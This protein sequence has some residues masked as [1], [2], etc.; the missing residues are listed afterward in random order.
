MKNLKRSASAL[1]SQQGS[2]PA[3]AGISTP[4][5][6]F[7]G[8]GFDLVIG[9]GAWSA[10]LLLLAGYCSSNYPQAVSI[11]F[12][13]LALI[14]N[15]PHYMA[16]VY[17]AYRTR[18]DFVKYKIFTLHLTLLIGL[19]LILTH[20]SSQLLAFVFTLYLTWSPF[21]YTGQNFGIALLFARRNG[22]KTTRGSR[23]AFHTAFLASYVM[24]FL[25]V[26]SFHSTDQF[27]VT[28][29]IPL[30][31]AR[32]LW[33]A[34][35][36]TFI[37]SSIYSLSAFVKQTGW[38]AMTAP[39][40]LLSTQVAW[41]V[42]PTALTLFSDI[43]FLQARS[44]TAILAV[45]HSA[46]Y[47][48]IT[49]YYARRESQADQ[50]SAQGNGWRFYAYF[51]VLI[52][53]G[54][55]LFVP[56]PWLASRVLHIDFM[57]SF[58]A[59]TALVNIHHFLLDGAIWKLRDGRI[60]SLLLNTHRVE[61]GTRAGSSFNQFTGWLAG[62][63]RS[64]RLFRVTA[65]LSLLFVAG[66]DQLKF[67]YG[68]Q[69]SDA[70]SLHRAQQLNPYDAALQLRLAMAN[71]HDGNRSGN[72]AA[73]E[74]AVHINPTYRAA[75]D[76][77]A[78]LLI[79]S[80]DY[81]EAYAHYKQMFAHVRPDVNSLVNF[82]LLASRLSHQDEAIDAWQR[83][84]DLD[85]GQ[86]NAHL[87]LADALAKTKHFQEAIP[88]YEQYLALIADDA[89]ASTPRAPLPHP[90]VIV[91]VILQLASACLNAGDD[92]HALHYFS[93][94]AALAEKAGDRPG[95]AFALIQSADIKARHHEGTEALSDFQRALTLENSGSSGGEAAGWF[96]YGMFLQQRH[97]SPRLVFACFTRAEALLQADQNSGSGEIQD[98]P[99]AI[100]T[101]LNATGSTLD[102]AT[103]DSIRTGLNSVLQEAL[104]L[105][106]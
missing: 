90:D 42:I 2:T 62:P 47:L 19:L 35:L 103:V 89:N 24:F 11:A 57:P 20:V 106:L 56:G 30:K 46:Q 36:V 29:G 88:H 86:T 83:A 82:G 18:E 15:Y 38:R 21:H 59:F 28:L 49:S 25:A 27:I 67:Y 104:S 60:A 70:A 41:F 77:L 75:Q 69:A 65:V 61:N 12:Y 94:A 53:G 5:K 105:K 95:L 76:A 6:W 7:Y 55:A 39:I 66:L 68:A 32:I 78:R 73:L 52:V 16:T 64:A 50:A 97:A 4:S 9:C 63:R 74:E 102:A 80:G 71:E 44:T 23:W 40:V 98:L 3:T 26:H 92:D 31:A 81:K 72:R 13:A 33:A 48:W 17:R 101:E 34:M 99:G 84:L 100:K 1:S 14:F 22:V 54:I 93:Q 96:K 58:L 45:M 85:A 87:Y 43:D 8:S 51:S 10:P 79:E 37:V 91:R